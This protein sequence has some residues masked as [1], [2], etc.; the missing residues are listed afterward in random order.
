MQPS[1]WRS[2]KDSLVVKVLRQDIS[3][4]G[5]PCKILPCESKKAAAHDLS[6]NTGKLWEHFLW[7][8]AAFVLTCKN[9]VHKWCA[10]QAVCFLSGGWSYARCR[11][12]AAEISKYDA[13]P[14]WNTKVVEQDLLIQVQ[15][16]INRV[17]GLKTESWQEAQ[18][19]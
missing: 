16:Y 12:E 9:I 11:L 14:S 18:K 8:S 1:S 2:Y 15:Y 13:V 19:E 4:F 3:N 17:S 5:L 10:Q 7:T 6:E